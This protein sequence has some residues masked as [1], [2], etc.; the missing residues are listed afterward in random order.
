MKITRLINESGTKVVIKIKN[1]PVE[2]V[3][4]KTEAITKLKGISIDI[5]KNSKNQELV[6]TQD[7]ARALMGILQELF[8]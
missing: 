6:I 4:S 3:N 7:E 5:T 8:T 1:K 2:E